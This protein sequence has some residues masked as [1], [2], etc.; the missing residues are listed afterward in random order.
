MSAGING[1]VYFSDEALKL[2]PLLVRD[3][4]WVH[5]A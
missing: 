4:F 3:K 2:H 1:R 5:Y